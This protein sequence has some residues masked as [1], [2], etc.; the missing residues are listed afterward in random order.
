[1][2]LVLIFLG[3]CL[4]L[5]FYFSFS[6]FT[7]ADTAHSGPMI[8]V[9][10]KVQDALFKMPSSLPLAILKVML[11]LFILYAI[12]DLVIST[13]RRT[14]LKRDQAERKAELHRTIHGE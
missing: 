8:T 5:L 1:M 10:Q 13:V 14:R 7:G 2:L 12:F 6:S 9:Y 11:G 4:Y 3:I